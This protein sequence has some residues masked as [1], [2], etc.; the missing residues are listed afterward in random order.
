MILFGLL[1]IIGFLIAMPAS[2]MCPVC[3]VAVVSGFGLSRY[4]GIDDTITGVWIGALTIS[5]ILWTI[6]WMDKKK[7]KFFAKNLIITVSY[8][9]MLIIPLYYKNI[10]G[11]PLNSLY[12][13]D[14]IIFGLIWGSVLFFL[15]HVLYQYLKKKNN[16]H[17][18]FPY[19]KI[20]MA[21]VPLI[22]V[23]LIFYFLTK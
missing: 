7:I 5:L 19:E 22:V 12:G 3:T 20:V 18:H 9:A 23:S 10:I 4:L 13:I 17:A 8:I 16:G 15:S 6:D 14:R 11:H 1:I 21:V 2:A